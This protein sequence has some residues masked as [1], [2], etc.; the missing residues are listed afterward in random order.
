MNEIIASKEKSQ[1]ARGQMSDQTPVYTREKTLA[2]IP[3]VGVPNAS[4]GPGSW[5][6]RN[7]NAAPI[8]PHNGMGSAPSAA[9]PGK[10]TSPRPSSVA[11]KR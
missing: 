11:V 1:T 6:T 7:V 8:T 10:G 3:N 5:Q 9:F 2:P 4:A